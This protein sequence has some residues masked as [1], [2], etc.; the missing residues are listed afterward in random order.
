MITKKKI[1]NI[2]KSNYTSV[3]ILMLLLWFL[4]KGIMETYAYTDGYE[5]IWNGSTTNF[6]TAF[7]EQGRAVSGWFN[8]LIYPH[9]HH[10][11]DLRYLRIFNL[12]CLFISAVLIH[13]IL[14]RNNI[15]M[16]HSLVIVIVFLCSPFSSIVIHWEAASSCIW[17]YPVALFAGELVFNALLNQEN[18][19][20]KRFNYQV[21]GGSLLGIISL[22]IYQPDYT[23]FL[24]P[25][26]IYFISGKERKIIWKFLL[27]HL[28]IYGVY[29]LLFKLQLNQLHIPPNDRAGF[30]FSEYKP[31]WFINNAFFMS[32]HHV[33]IFSSIE[34]IKIVGVIS[35]LLLG[36][37]IFTKT[38]LT[39]N[40]KLSFI[41][42]LSMFYLLAYFP[43]LIS[44]DNSVSYRTMGTVT[45]L[46]STLL[47][48]S[49]I[50]LPLKSIYTDIL[51]LVI[52]FIFIAT[53]YQNNKKFT[54]VNCKEYQA[55]KSVMQEKLKN[56]FPKGVLVIMPEE[57]FLVNQKLIASVVTDEFGKLSNS[58]NWAPKYFVMQLIYELT[59]DRLKAESVEVTNYKRADL[60]ADSIV[61]KNDW[62]LDIEQIYLSKSY[63]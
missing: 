24:F 8:S 15:N 59:N 31:L 47:I 40:N 14:Y 39:S 6:I 2:L 63:K 57:K 61:C 18:I 42:M 50:N 58:V 27:R 19:S 36:Y 41:L 34:I 37:Y 11:S 51:L 44:V 33:F 55:V 32:L 3:F 60:P 38:K 5:F 12:I 26:F 30:A 1:L 45:L 29:F 49:I 20:T 62:I 43:S 7:I 46:S 28:V 25:A 9:I 10:V 56:G 23:A 13:R 53:A 16:L 48:C 22:F 21:Y 54:D 4:F 35:L 17:G 52:P